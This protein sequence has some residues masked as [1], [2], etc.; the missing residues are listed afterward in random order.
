MPDGGLVGE[1][2]QLPGRDAGTALLE[3]ARREEAALGEMFTAAAARLAADNMVPVREHVLY[4]AYCRLT[5][6]KRDLRPDARFSLSVFMEGGAQPTREQRGWLSGFERRARLALHA[7]KQRANEPEDARLFVR[8]SAD[9]MEGWMFVLPPRFGGAWVAPGAVLA[10]LLEQGVCYG[11]D[12]AR[13]RQACESAEVYTLIRVAKGEPSLPGLDGEICD[14]YRRHFEIDLRV[15]EDDTVDYRD[16]GWLQTISAGEV[17]CDIVP[18]VPPV[19]GI[20]LRGLPVPGRRPRKPAP[21]AGPGTRISEDGGALLAAIDGVVAY[22]Q[23]RFRVDPLLTIDGD[24]D[25]GVGNL[26][27]PGDVLVRGDVLEGFSVAAGGNIS[28]L[29]AVQSA[30]LTAGGNIRVGLGAAGKS[31]LSA[32]GDV[33]CRY[34]ES[35]SVTAGGRV[36]SGHIVGA[37]VLCDTS[38]HTLSGTGAIVGGWVSAHER[39]EARTVGSP[40]GRHTRLLLGSTAD[41]LQKRQA[42]EAELARLEA[43]LAGRQ[44]DIDY[45]LEQPAPLPPSQAERLGDMRAGLA[46]LTMQRTALRRELDAAKPPA[47]AAARCRLLAGRI[48]PPATVQIGEVILAVEQQLDNAELRLR[49]SRVDVGKQQAVRPPAERLEP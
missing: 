44:K 3:A 34:I 16:L 10:A 29:G 48:H 19:D 7:K 5:G 24:V 20:N 37:R 36:V 31:V 8:V 39:I 27:V 14:H 13:I 45:L 30:R 41:M 23:Q 35:C 25:T 22:K 28:V 15:R 12:E 26:D 17:I 46:A 4:S 21:P 32:G 2:G 49:G 38:V 6:E 42:L 33:L 40:G 47:G 18:P 11:V 43:E 9:A 1:A